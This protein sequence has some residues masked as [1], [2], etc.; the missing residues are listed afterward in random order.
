L[1]I[2]LGISRQAWIFSTICNYIAK[3][4]GSIQF[5]EKDA[6]DLAYWQPAGV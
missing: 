2:Q 3:K 1:D 4:T 5:A 6:T